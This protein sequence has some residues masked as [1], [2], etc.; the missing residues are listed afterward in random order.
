M[1]LI[2]IS[3]CYKNMWTAFRNREN[4]YHGIEFND[5]VTDIEGLLCL[6][7]AMLQWDEII[8][9]IIGLI[10]G[11]DSSSWFLNQKLFFF[12]SIS[13]IYIFRPA[14]ILICIR[15]SIRNTY[16]LLLFDDD[17]DYIVGLTYKCCNSKIF[18]FNI[19]GS[20]S[21]DKINE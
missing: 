8:F 21:S 4:E 17:K 20:K 15:N 2:K 18:K 14:T 13:I 11:I 12:V 9:C 7:L 3:V 6:R 5:F 10:H 16:L 1:F 19:K